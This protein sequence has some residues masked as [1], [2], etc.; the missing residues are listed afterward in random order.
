MLALLCSSNLR[1]PPEWLADHHQVEM[2]YA[3]AI[4]ANGE[5]WQEYG[6]RIVQHQIIEAGEKV[7]AKL[8]TMEGMKHHLESSFYQG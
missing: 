3:D 1:N 2:Q 5:W 4:N 8:D 7:V 6:P